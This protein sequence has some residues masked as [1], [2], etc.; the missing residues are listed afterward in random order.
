MFSLGDWIFG[1]LWMYTW[2]MRL[3]AKFIHFFEKLA[4]KLAQHTH[5]TWRFPVP[6]NNT[7]VE[8]Q[9]PECC[10]DKFKKKVSITLVKI[11]R[12]PT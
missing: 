2:G 8:E 4:N 9:Y 5:L 6:K 1:K 3:N 12:K 10:K 11:E 7:C